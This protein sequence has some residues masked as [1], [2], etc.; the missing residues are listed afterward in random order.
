MIFHYV[1]CG[2]PLFKCV[3]IKC[4]K[5]EKPNKWV[6]ER[7]RETHTFKFNEF[8]K[9][10]WQ[11]NFR[12]FTRIAITSTTKNCQCCGGVFSKYFYSEALIDHFMPL[13]RIDNFC[14]YI[15]YNF[16]AGGRRQKKKPSVANPICIFSAIDRMNVSTWSVGE[17]NKNIYRII[18]MTELNI[19]LK[20]Q[21]EHK[22]AHFFL[23]RSFAPRT[24]FSP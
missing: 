11:W 2:S 12:W 13:S 1:L 24:L 18:W 3:L 5:Q 6:R 14:K 9:A 8:S 15:E 23:L 17:K 20:I 22:S 7:E 16:S 19:N 10:S 4:T 21:L